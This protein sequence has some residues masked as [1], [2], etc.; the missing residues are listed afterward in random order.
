MEPT[1]STT[2][3]ATGEKAIEQFKLN[4]NRALNGE[5]I[6]SEREMPFPGRSFWMRTEYSPVY[7]DKSII[8]VS[9]MVTDIDERKDTCYK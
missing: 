5:S 2:R 3:P 6:I 8:G 9:I 1:Y 4:F 7:E